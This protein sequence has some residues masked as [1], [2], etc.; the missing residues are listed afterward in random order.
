M[1]LHLGHHVFFFFKFLQI[2]NFAHKIASCFS[3]ADEFIKGIQIML[4]G[5]HP[6][7]N[8]QMSS[9]MYNVQ[10]R[11]INHIFIIIL[12]EYV[13]S[14]KLAFL[15]TS[16]GTHKCSEGGCLDNICCFES[17]NFS[18]P[19]IYLCQHAILKDEN[20]CQR[21]SERRLLWN[22]LLFSALSGTPWSAAGSGH[23]VQ[24]AVT[25]GW[26]KPRVEVTAECQQP[27]YRACL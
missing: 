22:S 20:T 23:P 17:E 3:L 9:N 21:N 14:F 15:R 7:I 18:F 10:Q 2:W 24:T 13:W 11:H 16:L 27:S 5:S 19:N 6:K 8:L 25:V 1:P 12:N 26:L 4:V